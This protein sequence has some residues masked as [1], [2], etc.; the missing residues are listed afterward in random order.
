M[1]IRRRIVLLSLAL[2]L[3]AGGV[4]ARHGQELGTSECS[5]IKSVKLHDRAVADGLTMEINSLIAAKRLAVL[6]QPALLRHDR[7]PLGQPAA[8]ELV[9]DS[10]ELDLPGQRPVRGGGQHQQEGLEDG[11]HRGYDRRL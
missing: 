9:L 1:S 8:Q 10:E 3:L 2:L 7:N 4:F 11:F 5:V 6:D